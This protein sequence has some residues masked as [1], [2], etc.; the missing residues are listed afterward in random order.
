[1]GPLTFR[2]QSE[3]EFWLEVFRTHIE[4]GLV[5]D[6]VHAADYSVLALRDRCAVREQEAA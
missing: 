6:A 2:D 5:T 1:M 3:L 4:R